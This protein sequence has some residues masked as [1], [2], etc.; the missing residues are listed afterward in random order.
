MF[1]CLVMWTIQTGRRIGSRAISFRRPTRH[2]LQQYRYR[3]FTF[4]LEVLRATPNDS[5]PRVLS[6]MSWCFNTTFYD[7]VCLK[8]PHGQL[9]RVLVSECDD[10]EYDLEY[11]W[12]H[13]HDVRV[14]WRHRWLHKWT[15][16]RHF[17]VGSLLDTNP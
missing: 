5:S 8:G 7:S 2:Q 16:C 12:R 3:L 9:I 11:M 4:S 1:Y 6:Q 17:P 14:A 10:L 13:E 15:R